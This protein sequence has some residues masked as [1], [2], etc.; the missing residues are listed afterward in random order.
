MWQLRPNLS[1]SPEMQEL[2]RDAGN[3][4]VNMRHVPCRAQA[5]A[6]RISI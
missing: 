6:R 3:T 1:P 2:G 5:A 4:D